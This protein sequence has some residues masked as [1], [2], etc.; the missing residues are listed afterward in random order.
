M[1]N[2]C[3]LVKVGRRRWQRNV[4]QQLLW[5]PYQGRTSPY[6]HQSSSLPPSQGLTA[7]QLA[8]GTHSKDILFSGFLMLVRCVQS[9]WSSSRIQTMFDVVLPLYYK[10]QSPPSQQ[11][12][13]KD[14]S[15]VSIDN[16]SMILE[17]R[18]FVFCFESS[19]CPRPVIWKGGARP[20]KCVLVSSLVLWIEPL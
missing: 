3:D 8:V 11:Q 12:Q 20:V 15:T 2:I 4:V 17:M 16:D 1:L 5:Y 18:N 6:Q 7:L 10:I 9:L 14:I 13:N 19:S